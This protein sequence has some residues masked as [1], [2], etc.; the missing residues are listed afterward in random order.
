MAGRIILEWRHPNGTFLENQ[1]RYGDTGGQIDLLANHG[2]RHIGRGTRPVYHLTT[3]RWRIV[4]HNQ[5][6]H[7]SPLHWPSPT[8]AKGEWNKLQ[9]RPCHPWRGL[10]PSG[11]HG[12]SR[13][14]RPKANEQERVLLLAPHDAQ[15]RA[16]RR[17][18]SRQL[19][20]AFQERIHLR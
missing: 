1:C 18:A 7:V 6:L 15:V 19:S 13:H 4:N 17:L 10:Q 12:L 2:P 16:V 8:L 9:R 5:H 20:K 11:G 14:S 3:P